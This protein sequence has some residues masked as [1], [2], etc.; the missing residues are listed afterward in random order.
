[1]IRLIR[2]FCIAG[3]TVLLI[4]FVSYTEMDNSYYEKKMITIE[5]SDSV[6]KQF[7]KTKEVKENSE[8]EFLLK[9]YQISF[10][11]IRGYKTVN[12]L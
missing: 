3:I 12:Q 2:F 4:L 1:M 11:I 8:T 5:K 6:N 10:D 9:L 7:I